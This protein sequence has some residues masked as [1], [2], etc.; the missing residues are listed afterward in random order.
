M[1][2]DSFPS[3]HSPFPSRPLTSP[4]LILYPYSL[5]FLF[6]TLTFSLT[7]FPS[8]GY[9]FSSLP[10]NP[11]LITIY[12]YS[13]ILYSS[14]FFFFTFLPLLSPSLFFPSLLLSPYFLPHLISSPLGPFSLSLIAVSLQYFL[15]SSFPLTLSSIPILSFYFLFLFFFFTLTF[16]LLIYN[17]SLLP[18]SISPF[19]TRHSFQL[20]LPSPL[21]LFSS[22]YSLPLLPPSLPSI[23]PHIL[24]HLTYLLP[25]PFPSS[26][27]SPF[28]LFSFPN[29][30]AFKLTFIFFQVSFPSL[31]FA[32]V[33]PHAILSYA[34]LIPFAS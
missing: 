23:Y 19:P 14:S 24:S 34:S 33:S 20:I 22:T 7:S 5:S 12:P 17:L 32:P 21:R 6:F 25:S 2:D 29:F 26:I 4:L 18:S 16:S 3:A 13:L 27:V 10:L 31:S 9:L 8:T 15:P 1:R 28:L 11:L 30:Q